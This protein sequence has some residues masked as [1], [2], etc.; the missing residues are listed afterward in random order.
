M[1]NRRLANAELQVKELETK[2]VEKEREVSRLEADLRLVGTREE[3]ERQA[4]KQSDDELLRKT[5][6]YY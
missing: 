4:R 5:V 3:E 2:L 1:L 6:R